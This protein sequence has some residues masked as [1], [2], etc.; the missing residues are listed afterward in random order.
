MKKLIILSLICAVLLSGC[1][2]VGKSSP[3][4]AIDLTVEPEYTSI[5]PENEFTEEV[6]RPGYGNVRYICDYSQDGRYMI[7]M[8]D[9]TME[10]SD[11]YVRQLKDHG[12]SE[13]ASE[14]NKVSTG[15][16]LEQ[17]GVILSIAFSGEELCM[18]I[19]LDK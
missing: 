11:E 12:F 8:E 6:L 1:A 18:L 2:V 13:V 3:G 5:W 7:V 19:T 10:Q 17:N 9:I 4:P 14:S 15:A 16:M